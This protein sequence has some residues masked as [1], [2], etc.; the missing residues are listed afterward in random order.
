MTDDVLFETRGAI[1]L[2]TLNRPKALNALNI[3]MIDAIEP[4]LVGW[5]A[6][7]GIAAVVIRGAGD[8]AFCAGGDLRALY[9]FGERAP[10]VAVEAPEQDFF[11]KEYT[12][13]WRIHH[14][15]KPYIA[16]IDG[17]TMGGRRRAVAPRQPSGRD[18]ADDR[19]DAGDRNRPVPGCRRVVVPQPVPPDTS[20]SISRSPGSI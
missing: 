10:R 1:G 18:R 2:I 11:R 7:P 19:R 17:I 13:N 14:F 5:A 9:E 20:G 6:D 16:L 15:P 4:R 12:L 8:R 3:P